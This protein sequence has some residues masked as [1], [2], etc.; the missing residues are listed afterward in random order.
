MRGQ[1]PETPALILRCAAKFVEIE[2]C[3]PLKSAEIC[4]NRQSCA[5]ESVPEVGYADDTPEVYKIPMVRM[6]SMTDEVRVL[7][8][9]A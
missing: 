3:S 8:S 9:I 4:S 7:G 2:P 6:S 1:R 5:V